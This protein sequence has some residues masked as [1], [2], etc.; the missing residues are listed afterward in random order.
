MFRIGG[1]I[2]VDDPENQQKKL[3][4]HIGKYQKSL[5]FIQFLQPL[6]TKN[7]YFYVHILSISMRKYFS[8]LNSNFLKSFMKLESNSI[9]TIGI[10]SLDL[11]ENNV[12]GKLFSFNFWNDFLILNH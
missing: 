11:D 6:C 10:A 4:I 8:F 12:P 9:I 7:P 5:S 3:R 1:K 2:K